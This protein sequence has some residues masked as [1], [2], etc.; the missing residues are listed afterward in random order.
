MLHDAENLQNDSIHAAGEKSRA[1]PLALML[2]YGAE[3]EEEDEDDD[4][5]GEGDTEQCGKTME[6]NGSN[7]PLASFF[8]ELHHEGLLEDGQPAADG[9]QPGATPHLNEVLRRLLPL[10]HNAV[11]PC[12][13][14]SH[15][16]ESRPAAHRA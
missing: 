1:N 16:L 5:D 14:H 11:C 9:S 7:D 3:D 10:H 6:Q 4:S 13:R 8:H 12:A 15:D 2:N